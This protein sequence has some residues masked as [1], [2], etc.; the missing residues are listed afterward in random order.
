MDDESSDFVTIDEIMEKLNVGRNTVYALLKNKQIEAF[1]I[2]RIWKIPY[3]SLEKFI[4]ENS[5]KKSRI[6]I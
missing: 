6:L 1:K 2:G 3:W 4:K 5:I